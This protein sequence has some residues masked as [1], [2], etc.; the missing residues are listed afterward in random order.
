MLL[1]SLGLVVMG[2]LLIGPR[3][4]G[5]VVFDVNTLVYRAAAISCGLQ[6]M[7]FWLLAKAFSIGAGLLPADERFRKL[8]RVL[9]PEVGALL[10][11]AL[12]LSGLVASG[13]AV[14][15]WSVASFGDLDPR[16]S[17]RRVVPTATVLVPGVQVTF[18][19]FF[20]SVLGLRTRLRSLASLIARWYP[21]VV[22]AC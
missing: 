18:A 6:A 5:S 16:E 2:L 17:L 13:Y 12:V 9:T 20:A 1:F 22:R 7:T 15:A 14:R 4:L 8:S 10:G 19:S 3:S 21:G 11:L